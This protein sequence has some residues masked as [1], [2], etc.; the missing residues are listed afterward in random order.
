METACSCLLPI[1]FSA[2]ILNITRP[3]RYKKKT[4]GQVFS[5]FTYP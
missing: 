1:I 2:I 5:I 4:Y 3:Q